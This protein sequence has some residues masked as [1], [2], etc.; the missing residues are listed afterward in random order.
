M[1]SAIIGCRSSR[2][3]YEDRLRE[4]DLLTADAGFRFDLHRYGSIPARLGLGIRESERNELGD[5]GAG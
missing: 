2:I 1:I 4:M 3:E 5:D